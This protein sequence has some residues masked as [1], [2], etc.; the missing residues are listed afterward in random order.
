MTNNT[1]I[2]NVLALFPDNADNEISAADM[3]TYVN[4]IFSDKET[5]IV[6]VDTVVNL[7]SKNSEIYEGSLV[8]IWN[9]VNSSRIGVYI[10]KVNQPTS[11]TDLIQLSTITGEDVDGSINFTYD[12]KIENNITI[13]S[14][15]Y[16]EV[17]RLTTPNREAGLYEIKQSVLYNYDTSSRSAYFRVS[18]DG[19]LTWLELRR[20][21]KDP[22]DLEPVTLVRV[23]VF[24][25]G[26]KDI[27]IQARCENPSDILAINLVNTAF[28]RVA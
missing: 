23:D 12:Y 8:V 17:L 15:T 20:E 6:K 27:I 26:I 22:T 13:Q 16:I 11:I 24:N 7:S 21:S 25:G 1:K 18:T 9:D 4:T 3:R 2:N 14:D 5:Q 28:H 19:G 10:S